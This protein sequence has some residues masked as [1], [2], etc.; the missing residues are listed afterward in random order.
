MAISRV[1]CPI[2][3]KYRKNNKRP[4]YII[5]NYSIGRYRCRT[6]VTETGEEIQEMRC[7]HLSNLGNQRRLEKMLKE[8]TKK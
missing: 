3:C 2:N 8:L 1:Y 4:S 6:D 5:Y 7:I